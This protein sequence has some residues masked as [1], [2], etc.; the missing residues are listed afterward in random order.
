M[1]LPLA[2][3]SDGPG[4]AVC[5]SKLVAG[6]TLTSAPV[7]TRNCRPEMVSRR[8]KRLLFWPPPRPSLATGQPFSRPVIGWSAFASCLPIGAMVVTH[9]VRERG[10]WLRFRLLPAR[11]SLLNGVSTKP[12]IPAHPISV[13]IFG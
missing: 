8:K 5:M 9:F 2:A 6:T 1:E 11:C 12:C 4:C 10:K 13:G 3:N 7:S